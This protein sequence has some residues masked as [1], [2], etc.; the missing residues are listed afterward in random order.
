MIILGLV[1]YVA[2]AACVTLMIGAGELGRARTHTEIGFASVLW[3]PMAI[4]ALALVAVD[5]AAARWR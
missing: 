5:A 4:A 3:L 2:V 1:F